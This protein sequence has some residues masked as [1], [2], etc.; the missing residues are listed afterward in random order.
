MKKFL[1]IIIALFIT[2]IALS[3][4]K[5]AT[6][7][8]FKMFLNTKTMVVLE[9]DPYSE[10]NDVIKA[11]MTKYW[12]ITPFEIITMEDF[13]AKKNN[14]AL[15]FML[16]SDAMFT[17][18]KTFNNDIKFQSKYTLLN[19]VLG[20][21]GNSLNDMPDLG[22]V[23][24]CYSELEV[25]PYIYKL[26][27][28]LRYMQYYVR[29]NIAHPNSDVK[30]VVKDNSA[31]IKTKELWLV[32]ED[33]AGS[34]NSIEKISKIYPYKVKFVTRE[35]IKKGIEASTEDFIFFHKIGPEG[36][37]S[38]GVCW[39]FLISTKDGAP[40]YFDYH[41]IEGNNPDAFLEKDFKEISK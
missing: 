9:D 23:P 29:Y 1:S 8:Q 22:S 6:T 3:Q 37:I 30:K 18:N 17:Q 33:L 5:T 11:Y 32:K 27:G 7:E 13:E 12:D 19:L 40:L 35:E 39:K 25:E 28:L 38:G 2:N 31:S 24:L 14:K 16:I 41:K 36:K 4:V 20:G 34:V 10:F 21:K 26:G 15:S